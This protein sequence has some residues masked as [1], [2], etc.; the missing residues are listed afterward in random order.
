MA[1]ATTASLVTVC[2]KT[3]S[4]TLSPL[5]DSCMKSDSTQPGETSR[6]EI[7]V[8]YSSMRRASQK[9]LTKALVAE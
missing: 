4:G 3:F 9:L 5:T 6:T 2:L 1:C 7:P 8:P